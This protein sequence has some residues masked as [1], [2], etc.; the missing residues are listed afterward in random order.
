METL[1]VLG[2]V[3]LICAAG[4]AFVIMMALG[5][6]EDIGR[7]GGVMVSFMSILT[8]SV[9]VSLSVI[10]TINWLSDKPQDLAVP[11]DAEVFEHAPDLAAAD[12]A[13][14]DAYKRWARLSASVSRDCDGA[15]DM[16]GCVEHVWDLQ[17]ERIAAETGIYVPYPDY[18][19]AGRACSEH[20]GVRLGACVMDFYWSEHGNVQGGTPPLTEAAA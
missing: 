15:A 16:D 20:E 14:V 10:G 9:F 3:W 8:I 2:L 17:K 12:A 13:T 19:R 6:M 7:L 4:C 18:L 5:I 1:I 11:T